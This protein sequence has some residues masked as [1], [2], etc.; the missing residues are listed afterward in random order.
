MAS[1]SKEERTNKVQGSPLASVQLPGQKPRTYQ[2]SP[3]SQHE[4]KQGGGEKKP[5]VAFNI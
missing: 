5:L 3:P 2:S 1:H 4:D